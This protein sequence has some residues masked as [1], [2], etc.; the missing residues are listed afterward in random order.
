MQIAFSFDELSKI[1]LA[2]VRTRMNV[3]AN[4][5]D[6]PSTYSK[7]RDDFCVVTTETPVEQVPLKVKKAQSC[8]EDLA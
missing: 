1:V 2:H 5:V 7:N 4:K 3:A 8:T 6:I